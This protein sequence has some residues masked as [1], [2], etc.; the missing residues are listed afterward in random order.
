[1]SEPIWKA[2]LS[3]DLVLHGFLAE[4]EEERLA[5]VM[6]HIDGAYQRGEQAGS[7]RTNHRLVQENERLRR[8]LQ[9]AQQSKR[10]EGVCPTCLSAIGAS[11]CTASADET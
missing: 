6:P 7:S 5:V 4:T 1:M 8:E 11:E 3:R 9:L 2:M 10:R